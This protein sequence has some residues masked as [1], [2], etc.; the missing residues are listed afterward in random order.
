MAMTT[1]NSIS[2]KPLLRIRMAAHLRQ[3]ARDQRDEF[4]N[5]TERATDVVAHTN[6]QRHLAM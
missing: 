4:E 2:V 6:S 5:G 1:S 3:K